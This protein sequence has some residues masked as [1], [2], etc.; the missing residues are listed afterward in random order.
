MYNSIILS[1]TVCKVAISFNNKCFSVVRFVFVLLWCILISPYFNNFP[2]FICLHITVTDAS[3]RIAVLLGF[4]ENCNTSSANCMKYSVLPHA[5][6]IF[7]KIIFI[8]IKVE[9]QVVNV[10]IYQ[11]KEL[12][13][14][15]CDMAHRYFFQ[16]CLKIG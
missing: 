6:L 9:S 5:T 14:S 10:F 15:L 3:C 16:I 13:K 11:L 1:T 2:V 4:V 8:K 12:I 7:G